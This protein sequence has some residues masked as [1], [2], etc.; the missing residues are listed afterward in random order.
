[1]ALQGKGENNLYYMI[2]FRN[3]VKSDE[4]VMRGEVARGTTVCV[5]PHT[6]RDGRDV[7]MDSGQCKGEDKEE[8]VIPWCAGHGVARG[9]R[10]EA[11]KPW[12]WYGFGHKTHLQLW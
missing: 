5:W 12:W 8:N 4:K 2:L 1:M 7:C 11:G 6:S 10:G 9:R 3:G